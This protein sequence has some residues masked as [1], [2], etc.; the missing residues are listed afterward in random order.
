MDEIHQR[1]VSQI[2]NLAQQRGITLSHLPDYADV[3]R[4]HYWEVLKGRSSPTLEWIKK[5][6]DALGVDVGDLLAKPDDLRS[7]S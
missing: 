1:L 6:A 4:S 7:P 5:V 3:G 2:Q